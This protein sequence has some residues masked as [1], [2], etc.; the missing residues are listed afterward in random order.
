MDKVREALSNLDWII[1]QERYTFAECSLAE[2][3]MH[4]VEQARQALSDLGDGCIRQGNWRLLVKKYEQLI[5]ST[6]VDDL[7]REYKFFGLIHSN[8]D[9][10]YGMHGKSGARFLSCVGDI[11]DHGFKQIPP[12][13][14]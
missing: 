4:R 7:G 1:E 12:E 6:F 10:Y 5:G 11:E 13:S 3:I 9:Y 2:E 8:D 14:K